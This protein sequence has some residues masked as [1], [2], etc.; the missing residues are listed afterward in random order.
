MNKLLKLSAIA[1]LASSTSLMAQT[2]SFE[3]A[4]IGIFGG[5]LG[6]EADGTVTGTATGGSGSIGKV[7]GIAGVDVSYAFAGGALAVGA[8]YVPMKAKFGGG[9]GND[10]TSGTTITGELKDHYTIYIQ[11]TYVVNKDAALFAKFAYA[12]ADVKTTNTTTAPSDVEGWGYGVGLK[13]F[14]TPNTFVQVEGIYTDYD[15]MKGTKTN[16]AAG[17]TSV[18]ADLKTVQALITLG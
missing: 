17:T 9:S 16:G 4:S 14:L 15:S 8:T 13:T 7:T 3:G 11:P 18:S 10:A 6:A 12:H 5:A 1:L 2:K